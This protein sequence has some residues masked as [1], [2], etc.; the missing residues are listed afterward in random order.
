MN[1]QGLV[2]LLMMEKIIKQRK[3]NNKTI[4][5]ITFLRKI[6]LKKQN[7]Q[8]VKVEQIMQD[9]QKTRVGQRMQRAQKTSLPQMI[10]KIIMRLIT[11]TNKI[12]QS[13]LKISLRTR[14]TAPKQSNLMQQVPL[15]QKDGDRSTQLK[16]KIQMPIRSLR[17]KT[18]RKIKK[19]VK[20]RI[21]QK[22]P[23]RQ[24]QAMPSPYL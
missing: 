4:P 3:I 16:V 20:Q 23:K 5:E 15:L 9:L 13:L 24:V 6:S 12:V 8:K 18:R 10:K 21:K 14:R 1:K 7:L 17:R 2:S 22:I 11:K 19:K